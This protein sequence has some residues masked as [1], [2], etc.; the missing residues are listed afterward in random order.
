[1]RALQGCLAVALAVCSCSKARPQEGVLAHPISWEE[2]VS[3]PFAA[4]CSSCHSG[5]NAAAG[6]R[7]TSYLEALGP[8]GAPIAIAGD[9]NSRLLQVIDPAKADAVHAPVSGEF[10]QTRQWVVDG[11]LS[12]FRSGIHE[13]GIMNP[14]DPEFHK[15]LV[16][17]RN[18]NFSDCQGCHGT[19]LSGGKVAVSC[20]ECH[21]LQVGSDGVP[22]C[23]SCH[24]NSQSQSPAP[25]RSLTGDTSSSSTGVGAHQAHLFGHIVISAPIACSACHQVPANVGSPGHLDTLRPAEVIFSGLAVADS[26]NPTWNETSCSST[27]C[28]GGGA[29]LS[30][31]TKAL[32]Q[33]PAWTLG[34]SQVFCGSCHGVPPSTGPHAGVVYP[35]CSGCHPRTVTPGGAIIVSGPPEARTS[36]HING[37]IDVGP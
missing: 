29:K 7:T 20:N 6:Y 4:R 32:L 18:W 13:G 21:A 35:N 10:E 11:R 16:R 12:F 22:T 36:F 31:D 9:P 3:S 27:Y 15:Y 37:V 25:P 28:H 8:T 5:P 26:A 34:S 14:N 19:D 30:G 2:D 23:T 17:D 1:M 33:T 24:G